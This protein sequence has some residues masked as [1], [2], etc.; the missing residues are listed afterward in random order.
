MLV[1]KEPS[2]QETNEEKIIDKSGNSNET[3]N[4]LKALQENILK[5]DGAI[6][7]MQIEFKNYAK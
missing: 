6:S 7:G 2:D 1:G 3:M 5:L 4:N